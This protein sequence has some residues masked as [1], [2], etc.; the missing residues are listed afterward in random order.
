MTVPAIAEVEDRLEALLVSPPVNPPWLNGTVL[1]A[2][3]LAVSG[4]RYRYRVMG[5]KR[6]PAPFPGVEVE[7]I[8]SARDKKGAGTFSRLRIVGRL[9]TPDTCA[10]H[11]FFFAPSSRVSTAVRAVL[12]VSRKP[13]IHTMPSLPAPEDLSADRLRRLMFADWIVAVSESSALVL[14]SAGLER[15]RVIRPAVYM[16]ERPADRARSRRLLASQRVGRARDW[17]DDPVFLYAGDL[18][19][20]NGARVFC[21]AAARVAEQ[22]PEA[23]FVLAC[24]PKTRASREALKRLE[25]FIGRRRLGR[26]VDFVGV[27]PDMPA[28]LGAVD[29][30]AMPV[31]TLY[32]KVDLPFVLLEA[33]A[34]GTPCIVSDVPSLGELAG[35]GAGVSVV[36]RTHPEA[37][38]EAFLARAARL[39]DRR[40][41]EAV[42]R[43]VG[44]W[45]DRH[46]MVAEYEALYDEVL[47]D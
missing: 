21:E 8:Y 15:V 12:A 6:E 7:E 3:D 11:H 10:L 41:R 9:L 33:M 28:L 35:L 39:P 14:K 2:R 24:R 43:V 26:R 36:P 37:L 4:E 30:L 1:L 46:R 23:R 45:F 27:V 17:G 20:S 22:L 5:V 40:S 47:E 32:A 29:A 42:R 16:P 38:A 31:D 25:R 13:S 19:F 34:L 44:R 18:E